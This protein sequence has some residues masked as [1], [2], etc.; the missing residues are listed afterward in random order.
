MIERIVYD[1]G[2]RSHSH[3]KAPAF[4][5]PWVILACALLLAGA[6]VA[7]N[8]LNTIGFVSAVPVILAGL[9]L[10]YNNWRSIRAFQR[11]NSQQKPED[12]D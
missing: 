4:S 11:M 3:Y 1:F 2:F 7:T 6:L 8:R 12:L 5:R 9:L 10:A